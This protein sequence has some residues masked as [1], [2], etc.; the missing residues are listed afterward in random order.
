M[1]SATQARA[2]FT[3]DV[4]SL[5]L[6]LLSQNPGFSTSHDA[7]TR[8]ETM[9]RGWFTQQSKASLSSMS[10]FLQAGLQPEQDTLEIS[11]SQIDSMSELY[12]LLSAWLVSA[13]YDSTSG[14]QSSPLGFIEQKFIARL[15]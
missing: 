2:N 12:W 8:S 4:A 13:S 15:A 3:V 11:E 14:K 10:L 9:Y 7:Q 6:N 5:R 1:A